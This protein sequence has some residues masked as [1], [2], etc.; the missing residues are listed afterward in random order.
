MVRLTV[1]ACQA[2]PRTFPLMVFVAGMSHHLRDANRR[3][4]WLGSWVSAP[5]AQPVYILLIVTIAMLARP[6]YLYLQTPIKTE[7]TTF[8][9]V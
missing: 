4:L 7:D 3:G 8:M 2:I 9:I 1:P 6:C 5:I